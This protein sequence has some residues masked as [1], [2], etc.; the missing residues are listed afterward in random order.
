M[1]WVQLY[2]Q[3]FWHNVQ[4]IKYPTR[5][6]HVFPPQ[7]PVAMFYN[8]IYYFNGAIIFLKIIIRCGHI[9]LFL[10]NF[11]GEKLSFQ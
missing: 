5:W 8:I 4:C 10:W 11:V 1:F 3:H 9:Y 6:F 7:N 2:Q